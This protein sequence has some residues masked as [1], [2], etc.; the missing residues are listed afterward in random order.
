MKTKIGRNS[1]CPCGSGKKYKNCCQ[2]LGDIIELNADPWIKSN[3]VMSALK[4]KLEKNF[5]TTTRKVRLDAR[6]KFFRLIPGNTVPADHEAIFSD[7][8]WF[9]LEIHGHSMGVDYL[10]QHDDS[11]APIMEQSLIALNQSYLSV[12][13]V[14]ENKGCLLKVKD[15]LSEESI[16]ILL[17]E[18]WEAPD[19]VSILLMGRIVRIM[20]NSIFSGM[21]LFM[22]ASKE[23]I[24]F[25]HD[26]V[27]H[28]KV[29]TN[30]NIPELFKSHGEILLGIFDHAYQKNPMKLQELY[31]IY[32][33]EQ[34]RE[35]L[36]A[37]LDSD[38]EYC[39]VYHT[40]GFD[41]YEPRQLHGDYARIAIGNELALCTAEV[42]SDIESLIAK[43]KSCLLNMNTKLI[44][45]M[46]VPDMLAANEAP[47]WFLVLKDK[48]TV[49]W[50]STPQ[51]ELNNQT[52]HEL[53]LQD[54]G[55]ERILVYLEG[56]M[57]NAAKNELE[58]MQD[59]LGYIRTRVKIS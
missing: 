11:L 43:L 14:I 10:K 40:E 35:A 17:K 21:V 45:S 48:E 31:C 53:L 32:L 24:N 46:L 19:W 33:N 39:Y 49:R 5:K 20:E 59:I 55:K 58:D 37:G 44:H 18:P 7:W 52:P 51:E 22:N 57:E 15:I 30:K 4:M 56:L 38:F 13:Q 29:L 36:K 12:Y 28:W 6:Q 2:S 3:Q 27:K 16:E 50:L 23:Q 8:L 54:N 25:I 9:D 41:W 34:E 26:H 42:L 47:Y 1:P